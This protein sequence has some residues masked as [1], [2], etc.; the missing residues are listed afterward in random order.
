MVENSLSLLRR[1]VGRDFSSLD[2]QERG[3]HPGDQRTCPVFP[4]TKPLPALSHVVFSLPS[5]S[6][7]HTRHR[8]P[9]RTHK[10]PCGPSSGGLPRCQSLCILATALGHPLATSLLR[11]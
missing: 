1:H 5:C 6:H 9:G 4:F 2:S 7:C 3:L 10:F 8:P 11:L